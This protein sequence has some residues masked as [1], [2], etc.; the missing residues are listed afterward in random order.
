MRA[1]LRTLTTTSGKGPGKIA[2][3]DRLIRLR[4]RVVALLSTSANVITFVGIALLGGLASSWYLIE[5]GS[6]LN[7]IRIGSWTQWTEAGKPSAD[8]YTRARFARQGS[9]ALNASAFSRFEAISDSEGRRLHS[10]CDY[11]L[12]G[13][14]NDS[15]WWTIAVFAENGRLIANPAER[16]GFD[17]STLARAPDGRY[18]ITLSRDVRPGNWLPTATAGRMMLVVE[19]QEAGTGSAPIELPLVRRVACS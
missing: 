19:V 18:A 9:L 4:R 17:T 1:F 3:P 5:R 12:E 16:Y 15:R 8:P 13:R 2:L 6:P 11:V 10:S 14:V 7:S